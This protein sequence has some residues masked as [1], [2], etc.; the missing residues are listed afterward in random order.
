MFVLPDGERSGGLEGDAIQFDSRQ[1]DAAPLLYGD[2]ARCAQWCLG[3]RERSTRKSDLDNLNFRLASVPT[4][5]QQY[6]HRND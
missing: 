4:G 1:K 6:S 5:S 2:A 3:C